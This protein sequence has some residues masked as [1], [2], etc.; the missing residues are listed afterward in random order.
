M[1]P[2]LLFGII[3]PILLSGH[4]VRANASSLLHQLLYVDDDQTP[5]T[6]PNKPDITIDLF[7]V[8]RSG[9]PKCNDNR[10]MIRLAQRQI[11][12]PERIVQMV[13]DSGGDLV[14]LC[15]MLTVDIATTTMELKNCG[16]F[17]ADNLYWLLF[18]GVGALFRQLCLAETE[19]TRS[20]DQRVITH[21]ECL[22]SNYETS[23]K[24][25]QYTENACVTCVRSL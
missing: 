1:H 3:L 19:L 5:R 4:L 9:L 10:L 11:T 8:N 21:S 7:G 17:E 20:M 25:S 12:S 23:L 18:K 6:S 22:M 24:R 14:D 2:H 15:R 13:L 16:G